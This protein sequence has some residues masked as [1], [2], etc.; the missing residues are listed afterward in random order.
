MRGAGGE[1]W[2]QAMREGGKEGGGASLGAGQSH[3]GRDVCMREDPRG[4]LGVL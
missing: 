4:L 1:A 3:C 2:V